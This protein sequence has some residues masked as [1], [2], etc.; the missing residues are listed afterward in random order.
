MASSG[1]SSGVP[2]ALRVFDYAL[3]AAY[4][5]VAA[6]AALGFVVRWRACEWVMVLVALGA[7][8]RAV[9]LCVTEAPYSVLSQLGN[10]LFFSVLCVPCLRVFSKYHPYESEFNQG[11]VPWRW[12]YIAL[13]LN[14]FLYV[15][16]IVLSSVVFVS[17]SDD[18]DNEILTATFDAVLSW[19]FAIGFAGLW[20]FYLKVTYDCWPELRRAHSWIRVVPCQLVIAFCCLLRAVNEVTSAVL[21]DYVLSGEHANYT[22]PVTEILPVLI[23]VLSILFKQRHLTEQQEEG[24]VLFDDPAF[25]QI[26]YEKL[27]DLTYLANGASSTVY[28]GF[29]REGR[30]RK[31]IA[32]K[33][34]HQTPSGEEINEIL[35]VGRLWHP[36]IVNFHG[37]VE[38]P[39]GQCGLV[40]D[41][42]QKGTLRQVLAAERVPWPLRL[43]MS[44]GIASGM[45]Y[46][47][48]R[49]IVHR[50][51]KPEN[52]LVDDHYCCRISDFG[53][54]VAANSQRQNRTMQVGTAEYMAPEVCST[55]DYGGQVDV[56]SF[57]IVFWVI[58]THGRQPYEDYLSPHRL[59]DEVVADNLRPPVPEGL[60]PALRTLMESCWASQPQDRPAFVAV[61]GQLKAYSSLLQ[62]RKL[63]SPRSPV[64]FP[65]PSPSPP[66]P[67]PPDDESDSE[68]LPLLSSP[69]PRPQRHRKV[70]CVGV[71][72]SA[73]QET[74]EATF[75]GVVG[76]VL[77][78]DKLPEATGACII[79]FADDHAL[80]AALRTSPFQ[81]YP[82]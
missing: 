80:D 15:L 31:E 39:T 6:G 54:C 60:D 77:Y 21:P 20:L 24:I 78:R 61:V 47:H 17:E 48:R 73:T 55:N 82:Q 2:E 64:P 35:N 30:N 32:L 70:L 58:V 63:H 18:K 42:A 37:Y 52:I 45:E 75:N 50:D 62:D 11:G 44:L 72:P 53:T 36:N 10:C 8:I 74:I 68:T 22:L 43:R 71:P 13:G 28:T 25:K 41:F 3:G 7:S 26:A 12:R 59:L 66:P 56:Y 9:D 67:P 29:L 1:G 76:A 34:L 14:L 4:A 38:L 49:G 46:I 57:G 51:L 40:L 23:A 19:L 27:S 69:P 65:S 79:E 5:A 16:V 33:V 81:M